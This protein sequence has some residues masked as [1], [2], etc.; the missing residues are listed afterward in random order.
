[1]APYTDLCRRR[2]EE[3]VAAFQN[4]VEE[5]EREVV[6]RFCPARVGRSWTLSSK[7][8]TIGQL[9]MIAQEHAVLATVADSL[10]PELM[11]REDSGSDVERLLRV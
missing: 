11:L 4:G 2:A 3:H 9:I 1:M 8:P 5:Y 10:P 7:A 6:S